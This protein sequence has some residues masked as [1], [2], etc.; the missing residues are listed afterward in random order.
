MK[1]KSIIV[2]SFFMVFAIL[3]GCKKVAG[4]GGKNTIEGTITY[5]N[6]VTGTNNAAPQA[7]VYIAYGTTASPSAFD[8]TIVT[9]ADGS[10]SF[11]GLNKGDYFIKAE[12]TDGNG[13]KYFTNGVAV[14]L[15]NKKNKTKADIVLE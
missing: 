14:T 9:G 7:M 12:Y 1:L 11:E 2:L 3:S 6:G 8:K 15:K 13:F 5:K 4:P 10:F